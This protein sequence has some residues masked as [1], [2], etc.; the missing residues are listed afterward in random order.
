MVSTGSSFF[1]SLMMSPEYI[2]IPDFLLDFLDIFE[3]SIFYYDF[4]LLTDLFINSIPFFIGDTSP[5]LLMIIGGEF[6]L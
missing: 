1:S 3:D 5:D 4:Y 2:L 6:S